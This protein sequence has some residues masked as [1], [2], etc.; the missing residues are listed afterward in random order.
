MDELVATLN[1]LAS[2]QN[3]SERAMEGCKESIRNCQSE[4]QSCINGWTLAE[5]EPHFASCSLV[6]AHGLLNHP[7][8]DT[9][10]QLGVR[11]QSG[12]YRL[13]GH[14]R[15]ITLLDGSDDDDYFVIDSPPIHSEQV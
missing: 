13:I 7:F 14:Y 10:L 8:V 3:L 12:S 15:L 9:K 5:I 6:F 11:D 2:T 1:S 4:G